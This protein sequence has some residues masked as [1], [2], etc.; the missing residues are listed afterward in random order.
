MLEDIS[1]SSRLRNCLQTILELEESLADTHLGPL[2]SEEFLMLKHVT[3]RL[4]GVHIEEADVRRIEA[5]TDK[6]LAELK[7]TFAGIASDGRD[8]TRILQ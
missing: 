2:L 8:S 7:E 6:F 1:L 5:A 3:R 4:S